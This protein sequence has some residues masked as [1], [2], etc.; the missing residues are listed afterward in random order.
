MGLAVKTMK[1]DV[2]N[3]LRKLGRPQ[4]REAAFVARVKAMSGFLV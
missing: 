2:L 4:P 3:V 1:N